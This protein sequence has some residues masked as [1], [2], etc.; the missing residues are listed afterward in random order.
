MRTFLNHIKNVTFDE[1]KTSLEMCGNEWS[2]YL[3]FSKAHSCSFRNGSFWLELAESAAGRVVL[4]QLLSIHDGAVGVTNLDVMLLWVFVT[5][6]ASFISYILSQLTCQVTWAHLRSQ[7]T[8]S[9][10]LGLFWNAPYCFPNDALLTWPCISVNSS[11][12][13]VTPGT[14]RVNSIVTS[15]NAAPFLK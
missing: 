11:Y 14:S 8:G 10:S 13:D 3:S 6:R 15:L 4:L 9:K 12:C 2:S 7:V 5:P 1:I